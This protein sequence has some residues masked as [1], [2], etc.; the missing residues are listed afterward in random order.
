MGAG[1]WCNGL[2]C[3]V[4]PRQEERRAI[5]RQTAYLGNSLGMLVDVEVAEDVAKPAPGT[6]QVSRINYFVQQGTAAC[7]V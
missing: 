5:D 3:N 4:G 6:D 7:D 2:G 1:R